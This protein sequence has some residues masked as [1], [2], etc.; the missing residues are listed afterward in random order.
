MPKLSGSGV[1][2]TIATCSYFAL[3]AV[4]QHENLTAEELARVVNLPEGFARFAMQFLSE[5][6][7]IPLDGLEVAV[8]NND[9]GDPSSGYYRLKLHGGRRG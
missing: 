1:A 9:A 8:C 4:C 3:A 2:T 5:A 7:F 6:G